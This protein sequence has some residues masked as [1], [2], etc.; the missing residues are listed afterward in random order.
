VLGG[1]G[2]AALGG[3]VLDDPGG[4]ERAEALPDV[5]L[6]EPGPLG[7]LRARAVAGGECVEEP[8]AVPEVDH[9]RDHGLGVGR[10]QPL[11]EGPDP[12][13]IEFGVDF[14]GDGGH[15]V[16]LAWWNGMRGR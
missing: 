3:G 4:D 11:G 5:A 9:Q 8:G 15:D 14:G 10:E 12:G 13:L 7:E 6:G 2:V 1:Q 16:L